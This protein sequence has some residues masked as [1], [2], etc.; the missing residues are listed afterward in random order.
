MTGVPE[1]AIFQSVTVYNNKFIQSIFYLQFS[2]VVFNLTEIDT[3]T[4]RQLHRNSQMVTGNLG[5]SEY[6]LTEK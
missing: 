3:K 1:K 5:V 6:L 2:G 4:A